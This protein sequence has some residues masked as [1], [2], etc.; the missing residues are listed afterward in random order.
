[1]IIIMT[2]TNV[3]TSSR[4]G[5]A[6]VTDWSTST[7][8]IPLIITNKVTYTVCIADSPFI[9]CYM[10]SRNEFIAPANRQT[11]IFPT[12]KKL[13]RPNAR[14]ANTTTPRCE[15][16]HTSV[17]CEGR[18]RLAARVFKSFQDVPLCS[19]VLCRNDYD[20]EPTNIVAQS[21]ALKLMISHGCASD[22]ILYTFL[23]NIQHTHDTVPL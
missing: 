18:G 14:T 1:M 9:G 23:S 21:K 3:N 10:H 2:Q 12:S 11:R 19:L 7:T 8:N 4:F 16:F 17:L 22:S 15:I 20:K 5:E 6:E 13:S